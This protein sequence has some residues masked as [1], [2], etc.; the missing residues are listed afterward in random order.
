MSRL[1]DTVEPSVVDEEM[2]QKAVEDQ[3]P[4]DEAGKI[5]KE[6]GIEFKDV[7]ALRLD[8]KN[9]LKIDNLWCFVNLTKLQLDNNIIEKV[10]GLDMLTKLVWLDLSFN[11]I[12]VIEGL[13]KLTQLTDLTLYN[14]RISKIEN[15]DQLTK[16]HVFS[17]GNNNLAE[18]DNLIYLRR[19]RNLQTLNLNG[20][21]ISELPEYRAYVVAHLPCVEYLDYRLVDEGSRK[22]AYN[23]YDIAVQEIQHDEK[24]A[25]RKA[26]EAE[27]KAKEHAIHKAAFVE[28]LDGPQLFETMFADDAEGQKLNYMP[29]VDEILI[30]YREKFIGICKQIFDFGLVEYETRQKEVTMFWEC[31]NEAK[32]E[33]KKEGM[34]H[35]EEFYDFKKKL[36][37][38]LATMTDQNVVEDRVAEYNKKVAE[39]WDTLMAL[40][41]QLVD[42]LDDA[43]KDFERNMADMVATFIEYVQ[44]L[45]A[46]LRD[47]ETNQ[48][49]KL[50]EI[51][52]ATLEKVVKNEL[53]DE[54]PDDL[55]EV[56][57]K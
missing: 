49:E 27:A 35:I 2:L 4:K 18:L 1:Y 17:I 52:V 46:Q 25:Q 57:I 41:M 26:T 23:K 45:T 10:E 11:N 47:M 33:N 29:T 55:R 43:I 50:L 24:V 3:G 48:H 30:D 39:L 51:A 36:W 16:L 12:E 14:N 54:M 5:A 56:R 32:E 15:M 31:L 22:S 44:G 40:E 19:F 7:E 34:T 6:E 38:D 9:I 42:Q 13:D 37:V 8:F 28:E 20:N 21:P 53:D